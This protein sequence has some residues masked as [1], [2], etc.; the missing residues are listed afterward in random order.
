MPINTSKLIAAPVLQDLLVDKGGKPMANGTITLYHDLNRSF[1]KNWYYQTGTPGQYTWLPLPNPLT[2]SAAGTICD[3]NGVDTIPFYYPYSETDETV[4]DP[5]YIVILSSD[6]QTEITRANFPFNRTAGGTATTGTAFNNLIVNNGFWRNLFSNTVNGSATGTALNSIVA[7]DTNGN[8]AATVAP[9]QHDG[10]SMPDILFIKN[11]IT[12][13][14]TLTF[15]AFPLELDQPIPNSLVPEY[16]VNHVSNANGGSGE[17]EK[18][19]QFPISLHIN[20]LSSMPYTVSIQAQ[21][22][23][24]ATTIT[25]KILQ[26]TGTGTVSPAPYTVAQK[27]ITLTTAWAQYSLTDIFPPTAGL[28]LGNG[29]DDALYLQIWIPLNAAYTV[30]FTKPCLYL[31]SDELPAIEF[32]T[33]DQVDAIIN[34]PRTGDVRTSLNSFYPFGW[35]PMNDGSIGNSSSNASARANIDTWPLFNLLWQLFQPFNNGTTNP[36]GQMLDSTGAA[37]TYG[38]SAIA[39]YSANKAI[40]VTTVQGRVIMGTVPFSAVLGGGFKQGVVITNS[41]GNILASGTNGNFY[42]QGQPIY[43]VATVFPANIVANTIY[44]VTNLN[45]AG[46]GSFNIATTYANAIAGTPVLA[47][48]SAGTV[49]DVVMDTTGSQSGQYAHTQLLPELVNHTHDPLTSGAV[50]GDPKS[51]TGAL[52]TS[53]GTGLVQDATTGGVTGIPVTQSPFNIVQPTAFFNLFIKM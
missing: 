8:Y 39:D 34:S 24:G 5:Y 6:Q 45:I 11:N 18:Y 28:T 20:T 4:S 46:G 50:F 17:T 31:T 9:S 38:A 29:A 52:A 27:D 14:D 23:T 16:Y 19:Y 1:L 15:T 36:L 3:I 33:Y 48:G 41:G 44:Y 30:N 2:L 42:F 7:I 49:V 47:Y 21:N 43:F 53:L 25:L 32:E 26:F 37:V 22:V 40:I 10:F 12:A 35:I 13:T 51:A